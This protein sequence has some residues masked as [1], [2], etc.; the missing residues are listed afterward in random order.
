M[1]SE[2]FLHDRAVRAVDDGPSVTER[3]VAVIAFLNGGNVFDTIFDMV[4]LNA[5]FITPFWLLIY[6]YTVTLL[7]WHH[8]IGWAIW[9]CRRNTLLT[10]VLAA[11]FVSTVWSIDST[12]T[13]QRAIHLVGSSL[14]GVWFGYRFGPRFFF[15]TLSWT[16]SILIVGSLATALL[17]PEYGLGLYEGSYV[18]EGLQSDKNALGLTAALAVTYFTLGLLTGRMSR[19][20]CLCMILLSV[21]VLINTNSA[22]SV[23]SLAVAMLIGLI[24]YYSTTL[25]LHPLA[26]LATLIVVGSVAGLL[27]TYIPAEQIASTVG[28]SSSL[29]GRTDLWDATWAIIKER[30]WFGYGYGSIWFPRTDA[31]AIQENLLRITWIAHHAHNSFLHV[32]SELGMPIAIFAVALLPLSMIRAV[33]HYSIHASLFGLFGLVFETLFI[34]SNLTEVRIFVDRNMYWTLFIAVLVAL[35][36]TSERRLPDRA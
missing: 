28:R 35:L 4:G 2:A 10:I 21:I 31:T 23:L 25:Q 18:W 3:L 16:L 17:F 8:N 7:F 20:G 29:T 12:L 13:L 14:I 5:Q 15:S 9:L 30:P 1:P 27:A 26:A 24:F 19:A 33:Y 34:V 22:T 36:R 6:A 11:A 32:A